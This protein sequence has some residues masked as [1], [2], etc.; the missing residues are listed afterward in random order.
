[1]SDASTFYADSDSDGY[2]DASAPILDCTQPSGT[3]VDGSDCDDT[4]GAINPDAAETCDGVDNNCSG[5]E[6]DASDVTTF[7]ADLDADFYGDANNIF[8]ACDRPNGYR[9]NAE[10][11]DDTDGAVNPGEEDVCN[12]G[13]DNDCDGEDFRTCDAVLSDSADGQITGESAGDAFGGGLAG[14]GDIDGDSLADFAIS[15]GSDS[16]YIFDGASSWIGENSAT[17]A[18]VILTGGGSFSGGQDIDGDGFDDMLV[19]SSSLDTNGTDAGGAYVAYGPLSGDIDLTSTADATLLGN[20]AGDGAG[21]RALLIGDIDN[22]GF[23]DMLLTATGDDTNGDQS[24]AAYLILGPTTGG[25][26]SDA[27]YATFTSDSTNDYLGR[28]A[29]AVGDVDGDGSPDVMVNAYRE[30]RVVDESTTTI[31]T[32]ATYLLTAFSSGVQDIAGAASATVY[33]ENAL[34]QTG[35]VISGAGDVDGDGY[36]DV[37]IA[38][39]YAD[40]GS[41]TDSGEAYLMLGPISGDVSVADAQARFPGVAA[42]DAAGRSVAGLGD[43]NDDGNGDIAI[44]AKLA[45]D[46]ATDAGAAY[47]MLG[48]VSGSINLS[49]ADAILSGDAADDR[50][51][52]SIASIEDQDGGGQADLLIGA[53]LNDDSGSDAGSVYLI[54]T[55]RW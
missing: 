55:E 23:A 52:Q 33:G 53:T 49:L 14:V 24:G 28:G 17:A 7:Y 8:D 40:P 34:D 9:T 48:P 20:T 36:D 16:I 2:G 3:I 12:D 15:G 31:N 10:D 45:D 47:I 46:S 22:D 50:A 38:S 21:S 26:L 42:G 44:G 41:L 4:D 1:A 37:L 18:S 54:F 6:L 35:S 25:N 13:I 29:A 39:W 43:I 27:A 19:G 5:D 11:C 51:G 30:D 32:G